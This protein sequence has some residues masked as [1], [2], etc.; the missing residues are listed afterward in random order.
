MSMAF[1]AKT[2]VLDS[3]ETLLDFCCRKAGLWRFFLYSVRETRQGF[4]WIQLL[5]PLLSNDSEIMIK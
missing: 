1:V 2:L 5:C 4:Y 3:I